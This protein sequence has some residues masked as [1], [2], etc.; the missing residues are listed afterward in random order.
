MS[1]WL[2]RLLHFAVITL[3]ALFAI[4]AVGIGLPEVTHWSTLE[5]GTLAY[6]AVSLLA[7]CLL[8]ICAAVALFSSGKK[9]KAAVGSF[10][11][12]IVLVA[13]QAA[14]LWLKTI[15]CTTPT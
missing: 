12:A 3:M 1:R 11:A 6:Y 4:V 14:G 9:T 5:P 2:F 13:N 10:L 8:F 15:L 7:G